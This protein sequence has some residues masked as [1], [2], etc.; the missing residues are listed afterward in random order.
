MVTNTD[1]GWTSGRNISEMKLWISISDAEFAHLVKVGTPRSSNYKDTLQPRSHLWGDPLSLQEC[2][3]PKILSM[4]VK[5]F[6]LTLI[7][8]FNLTS[9]LQETQNKQIK[10][11]NKNK[12]RQF[13]NALS[14]TGDW[15]GLRKEKQSEEACLTLHDTRDNQVK[16][17]THDQACQGLVMDPKGSCRRCS[18]RWGVA[19]QHAQRRLWGDCHELCILLPNCQAA[20]TCTH[21]DRANMATC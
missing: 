21:T 6:N 18:S 17:G 14:A 9:S 1:S 20:Q 2:S 12:A 5:M 10:S 7:K 19:L 15:F 11:H 13:K 3:E 8:S 4:K 16:V